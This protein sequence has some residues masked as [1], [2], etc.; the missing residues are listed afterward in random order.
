MRDSQTTPEGAELEALLARYS[1]ERTL[2]QGKALYYQGD[3]AEAAWLV[4][5]GRLRKLRIHGETSQA[6]G[7][8]MPGAWLCLPELYLGLPCLADVVAV[9]ESTLRRFS[10]YNLFELLREPGFKDLALGEMARD[11][12]GLHGFLLPAGADETVARAIAGMAGAAA[13]STLRLALTQSEV[14]EAA[15]LARETVNRS[16]RR[17][18]AL[19]F[20]ET[21][22]GEILVYDLEGLRD[23]EP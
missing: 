17:L 4:A 5:S 23:Y 14:A 15:G 2:R 19:G 6:I 16:L 8:L 18:E 7:D 11:C 12:Y 13:G 3:E 1:G 10:R 9:E 20:I 22:R 21:G